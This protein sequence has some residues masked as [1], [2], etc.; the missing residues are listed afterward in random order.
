MSDLVKILNII[1]L[2][3]KKISFLIR[4]SSSLELSKFSKE[5]NLSGDNAKKL[6]LIANSILKTELS[7]CELIRKVGSEEED[8][9]HDTEY[10]NA[11]YLVCYD[12]LDGSSN[13]G[14]NITTGTIFAV[15]KYNNNQIKNGNN[16]VM[17]GY[18]LYGGSCQLIVAKNTVNIYQLENNEF[19]IISE[20][21]NIPEKGNYFSCNES[22]KYSL[23]D[24]RSNK[25]FDLL[26][27]EG[28]NFRWVGSL[29]ADAHR[30]LIKGGIFCY[31]ANVKNPHGKIRLLYE[32]YPF[33]HIFK[34]A[35][36]KS[37]NG[38]DNKCLLEVN[39]PKNIHQKTPII[40]SSNYEMNKFLEV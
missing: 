18:C 10:Q 25:L 28:Y 12:P 31:P 39:Y 16:I 35:G 38:K 24:H 36:G 15:Y 34:I 13:I 14:V 32:A 23:I 19:K 21:W 27:N 30:T 20:S 3:C 8:E 26:I 4:D 37:L 11:P 22:K 1:K 17:S 5:Y 33:A 9:L 7:N 29:V 40:L 2:S 6:D